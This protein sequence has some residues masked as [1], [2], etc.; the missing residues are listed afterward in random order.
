MNRLRELFERILTGGPAP[1]DPLYVTNRTLGQKLRVAALVA[2]PF[3]LLGGLVAI[4][5]YRTHPDAIDSARPV[6]SAPA[7]KIAELPLPNLPTSEIAI[8][9]IRVDA[10]GNVLVGTVRNTTDHPI[11]SA[12]VIF[13]LTDQ[14]GSQL[15]DIMH[16]FQKLAP[17]TT[18]QIRIPLERRNA[19]YAVVREI[20]TK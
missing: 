20:Q 10:A 3:A 15:G 17:K 19:A 2:L 12:T 1:A 16:T 6:P 9:E 4:L 18:V 13:N 7:V 14:S 11:D 8:D 5:N